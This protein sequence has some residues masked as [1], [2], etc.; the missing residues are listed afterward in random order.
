MRITLA[1]GHLGNRWSEVEVEW[2]WTD[3]HPTSAS[4]C[5]LSDLVPEPMRSQDVVFVHLLY[6]P[7]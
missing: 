2:P 5:E 7:S 1:V 6:C 3:K 4:E